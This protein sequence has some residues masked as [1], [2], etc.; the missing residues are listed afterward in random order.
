MPKCR[1]KFP[2]D[3]TKGTEVDAE[4]IEDALQAFITK[5][6]E[7]KEILS[8]EKFRDFILVL[9][10]NQPENRDVIVPLDGKMSIAKDAT[11]Q[12][13]L[14]RSYDLRSMTHP[15]RGYV[16]GRFR[17]ERV[18]TF[19]AGEDA[20][21]EWQMRRM[22]SEVNGTSMTL[23]GGKK[24][25][26]GT[27]V[28]TRD[29]QGA[30]Y[31]VLMSRGKE[32]VAMPCEEWYT[33]SHRAPRRV[34]TLEEAEA[35]MEAGKRAVGEAWGRMDKSAEPGYSDDESDGDRGDR[36]DDSSDEE[37]AFKATKRGKK[38]GPPGGG[39]DSDDEDEGKKSGKAGGKS[40]EDETGE[41]WE[42]DK[43]WDDDEDEV[44]IPD[45]EEAPKEVNKKIGGDS[46]AEDEGLDKEGLAVKKLLGKQEKMDGTQF[47]D[48]DS[49]S[50]LEEDFNPDKDDIGVNVVG[51]FVKQS[52]KLE[53]EETK[54]ATSPPA[55]MKSASVSSI[56]VKRSAS[57]AAVDTAPPGKAAKVAVAQPAAPK[58]TPIESTIIDIV[59]KNPDSTTV[60]LI[61]KT[62]RKK[63]LLNSTAGAEELKA[64]I[65]NLL[66]M[67]K[68][69]NGDQVLVLK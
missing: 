26:R 63:G 56:G 58:H 68:L 11:Y 5:K 49:D 9:S 10:E 35:K 38:K 39:L 31:F 34:L 18:P 65:K 60:K 64:A 13:H 52:K 67:K 24:S 3:L 46:D 47:S 69:R 19:V 59:R 15:T 48:S 51:S 42:H 57:D 21:V 16:V 29:A 30:S 61:T 33:F 32:F 22:K 43:E 36:R 27:F 45:D 28:G 14:S 54:A 17:G 55:M 50:E 66:V 44:A 12:A 37:D 1:V 6:P 40:K 7:L 2:S 41:D 8:S 23:T 25:H 20:P 53:A 4:T 62:C